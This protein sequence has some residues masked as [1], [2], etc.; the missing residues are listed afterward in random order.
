M[1]SKGWVKQKI[2]FQILLIAKQV[3]FFFELGNF[4]PPEKKKKKKTNF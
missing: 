4:L 3:N 1:K 2:S